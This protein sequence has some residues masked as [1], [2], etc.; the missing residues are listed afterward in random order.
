MLQTN[1]KI[2]IIARHHI[3][4][5]KV[6]NML[7]NLVIKC[8]LD[9][10]SSTYNYLSEGEKAKK[11]KIVFHLKQYL[12]YNKRSLPHPCHVSEI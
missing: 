11:T 4:L 7:C 6:T 12:K 5:N 2:R 10:F 9:F 1:L 8:Q 3:F